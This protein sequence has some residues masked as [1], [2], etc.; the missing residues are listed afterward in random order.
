MAQRLLAAS[1]ENG[2]HR[3]FGIAIAEANRVSAHVSHA[4]SV[5]HNR[6]S[7]QDHVFNGQHV[8]ESIAA[9]CGPILMK[10]KLAGEIQQ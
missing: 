8:F 4:G 10:K 3:G 6:I 2:A 5:E 7:Y 9:H 1:I